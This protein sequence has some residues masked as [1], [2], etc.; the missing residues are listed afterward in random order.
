MRCYFSILPSFYK[1]LIGLSLTDFIKVELEQE[2]AQ[3]HEWRCQKLST[4]CHLW[5]KVKLFCLL[6][7][8]GWLIP[9]WDSRFQCSESAC[10]SPIFNPSQVK[11]MW[12]VWGQCWVTRFTLKGSTVMLWWMISWKQFGF[13]ATM[14]TNS[15][16]TILNLG[17]LIV[18]KQHDHIVKQNTH[19]LHKALHK[20]C[21][22]I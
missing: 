22:E 4:K 11:M 13:P 18:Q 6:N 17:Q 8:A 20:A 14:W 12:G 15:P 21:V 19:R 10:S 9:H 5:I 16:K 7:S 2:S 3:Q 1:G